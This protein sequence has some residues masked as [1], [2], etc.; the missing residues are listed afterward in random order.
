MI[1]VIRHGQSIVNVERT[2]TCK[3]LAGDLTKRGRNQARKAGN[4]LKDKAIDR[5]VASPFHR[6]EQTAQIIAE[7]VGVNVTIDAGLGEM[8]CGDFEG[9]HDK[10]SWKQWTMIYNRWKQAEWGARFHGGESY[11]EGYDRLTAC[12]R[13]VGMDE[14]TVLVSHGGITRTVIPYLCVNAAALQ[15]VEHLSNTGMIILEP[16][17]DGRFICEVWDMKAHLE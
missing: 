11:R 14:N 17:G 1:Y 9:K 13:G 10:N 3:K 4:W 5:I 8:D 7:I 16:Y 6:A 2:L 15:R 12:L